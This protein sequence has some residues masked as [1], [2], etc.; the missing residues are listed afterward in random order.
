MKILLETLFLF[1]TETGIILALNTELARGEYTVV[2]RVSDNQGL[3]QDSTVQAEVCDCSGEDVV[4]KD[5]A[6]AGTELPIIL[7]ILGGILLLLSKSDIYF[8]HRC[9]D[10][11]RSSR[12]C[13]CKL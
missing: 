4:C 12:A 13:G 2:L 11:Y 6:T 8:I 1:V 9:K 10:A 7:G 5:R 3:A